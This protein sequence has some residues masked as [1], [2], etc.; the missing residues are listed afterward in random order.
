MSERDRKQV[1]KNVCVSVYVWG[2]A[3]ASLTLTGC[4]TEVSHSFR[5]SVSSFLWGYVRFAL[6]LSL[7]WRERLA[8]STASFP[9]IASVPRRF[10]SHRRTSF[11]PEI[12]LARYLKESHLFNQYIFSRAAS[13]VKYKFYLMMIKGVHYQ[14]LFF[15]IQYI[16]TP[17][18]AGHQILDNAF[19]IDSVCAWERERVKR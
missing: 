13:G 5:L 16:P 2:L 4:R 9:S 8:N 1:T 15:T 10:T 11:N 12:Y 14:F 7:Q 6:S 18:R 19:R 17:Y 3:D